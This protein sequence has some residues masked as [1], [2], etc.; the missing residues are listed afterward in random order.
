MIIAVIDLGT[1]TFNLASTR[2]SLP[3]L[4]FF[5]ELKRWNIIRERSKNIKRIK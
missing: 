1:N 2:G 5:A 4:L 3:I